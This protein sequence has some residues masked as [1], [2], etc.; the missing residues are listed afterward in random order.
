[1]RT[2]GVRWAIL[3]LACHKAVCSAPLRRLFL[4]LSGDHR[5][6]VAL[7]GRLLQEFSAFGGSLIVII[8][9]YARSLLLVMIEGLCRCRD[10]IVPAFLLTNIRRISIVC[11]EKVRWGRAAAHLVLLVW[12]LVVLEEGLRVVRGLSSR[13]QLESGRLAVSEGLLVL[14]KAGLG[15]WRLHTWGDLGL[16]LL[17]AISI[18]WSTIDGFYQ[19]KQSLFAE[20][21]IARRCRLKCLL[22][23]CL[24]FWAIIRFIRFN[25]LYWCSLLFF[26]RCC[27][28]NQ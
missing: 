17:Q 21:Q 1:M 7:L 27:G 9:A 25:F 3:R 15:K 22:R 23:C 5:V 12:R 26:I 6:C 8:E 19:L 14:S 10:Y 20:V 28:L 11:R 24:L 2:S 4:F 18:I 16:G 13:L